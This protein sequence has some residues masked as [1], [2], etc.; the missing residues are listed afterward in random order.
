ML[1]VII[2]ISCDVDDSRM[3]ER[4]T[5]KHH[6]CIAP[7]KNDREAIV[8]VVGGDSRGEMETGGQAR[9]ENTKEVLRYLAPTTRRLDYQREGVEIAILAEL[10]V[11][12][13]LHCCGVVVGAVKGGLCSFLHIFLLRRVSHSHIS[14]GSATKREEG[15]FDVSPDARPISHGEV[16]LS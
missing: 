2:V 16:R 3:G 11:D 5:P 9:D 7:L 8:H 1:I 10:L 15:N 4:E 13:N 6:H 14:Y 12:G